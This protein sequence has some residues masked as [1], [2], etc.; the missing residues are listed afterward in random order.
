MAKPSSNLDRRSLEELRRDCAGENERR[1]D[2]S[3]VEQSGAFCYELFRRAVQDGDEPAWGALFELLAPRAG[4]WVRGHPLYTPGLEEPE[5]FTN[6]A[7]EKMWARLSPERISQ[8]PD[9]GGV[10]RYLQMCIHS[11]LAQNRRGRE[12]TARLDEYS[13]PVSDRESL[14]A[15]AVPPIAVPAGSGVEEHAYVPTQAEKLWALVQSL[16]EADA[17]RRLV[18]AHY[19]IGLSRQSIAR[20]YPNEYEDT[21]AV[22]QAR[23]RLINRLEADGDLRKFL[24]LD[25]VDLGLEGQLTGMLYRIFCPECVELGESSL[26]ILPEARA[27]E[28]QAH[29]ATC[30][31]CAG[32]VDLL[33]SYLAALEEQVGA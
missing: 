23:A 20:Q 12:K 24:D 6:R 4:V 3:G 19:V 14:S 16:L 21:A 22:E 17:E 9:A 25:E 5:F 15:S 1:V 8:V 29:V 10:R 27:G 26:G 13:S 2:A 18:L 7:F 11:A 32:E 30:S 31:L 33:E 28:V